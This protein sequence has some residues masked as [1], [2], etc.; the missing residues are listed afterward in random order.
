[1]KQTGSTTGALV[2]KK[3]SASVR[4]SL[5]TASVLVA[6][7]L[8]PTV[9]QAQVPPDIPAP[10]DTVYQ[11]RL[12]DGSLI[13]GRVAEF[14]EETVILT[15]TGGSRLQIGRDQIREVRRAR[16]RVVEGEFWNDDPNHTRLHFTATGRALGQGESYAGT[17]VTYTTAVPFAA[18]G[19]TDR[20]SIA[21]GAPL[22]FFV[23]FG[24][25]YLDPRVQVLRTSKAQATL[26]TLVLFLDSEVVGIAYGVGT[27]GDRDKAV[28]AG[29]GF[30]YSGDE[31]HNEP[32]FMLGG[33]FRVNRRIKL[34]TE[35]YLL[36]DRV[37][38]ILSG[39]IRFIGERFATQIG[40]FGALSDGNAGCC[41]PLLNFS[42]AFGWN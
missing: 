15:T 41:F 2:L 28:S 36:P 1:M 40:V 18:F 32:A 33:E 16:G 39:G 27:F 34:I 9:V 26:G 31:V 25:V 23:T 17:Y 35:N 5:L 22:L 29:M 21:A 10:S 11:V 6:S 19:L 24:S 30:F 8:L 3:I 12:A 13:I 38:E 4:T 7:S 42:Y 37:G 14:N 20:I